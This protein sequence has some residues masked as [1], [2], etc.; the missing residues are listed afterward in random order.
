MPAMLYKPGLYDD[1][2]LLNEI[3]NTSGFIIKKYKSTRWPDIIYI[4]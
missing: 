4:E 3:I 2:C 1:T